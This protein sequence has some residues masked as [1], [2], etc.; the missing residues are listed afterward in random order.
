[1]AAGANGDPTQTLQTFKL[2][3][4]AQFTKEKTYSPNASEF[5]RLAAGWRFSQ[6]PQS[7]LAGDSPEPIAA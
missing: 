6:V 4:L 3:D 7:L 2:V 5:D 1:M